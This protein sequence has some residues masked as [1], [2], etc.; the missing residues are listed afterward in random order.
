MEPTAALDLSGLDAARP[1]LIAGATASGKS[2][3]ALRIAQESGGVIVNADAMQVYENWRI[4][5]ARPSPEDEALSPHALYGHIGGDVPYSV[6][7][8]LRDVAALMKRPERLIITGGTGL[9]FSALSEGLADIPPTPPDLRAQAD[10]LL[11]ADGLA[12]M[13]GALDTETASRI[14]L[15]NPMRVQRAWEVQRL[16]GRGIAAWQSETPS[17]LLPL[18]RTQAFVVDLPKDVLNDRIATRFRRMIEAGVLDEARANRAHFDPAQ[19]SAKAIGARELIACVEG[20]MTLEQAVERATVA[21]RQ[22]AKRQRTW[23][24]ARMGAWTWLM[25]QAIP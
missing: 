13:A 4:L 21:T 16:T 15:N 23:F 3:L 8:W 12:A 6:G 24:R 18:D 14:D 20:S 22:F 17:P 7:T 9:Y 1:V 2:D 19:P 5:T 10:A 25:P 11:S